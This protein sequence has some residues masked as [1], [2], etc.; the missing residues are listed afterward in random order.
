MPNYLLTITI[1]TATR[2]RDLRSETLLDT[3][4]CVQD[5]VPRSQRIV[6]FNLQS[7]NNFFVTSDA[8]QI[9]KWSVHL[10][11]GHV[12]RWS[13]K[14]SWC[15]GVRGNTGLLF[16]VLVHQYQLQQ[17]RNLSTLFRVL[18]VSVSVSHCHQGSLE[19]HSSIMCEWRW[20]CSSSRKK[21][22]QYWETYL[23]SLAVNRNSLLLLDMSSPNPNAFNFHYH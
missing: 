10:S 22:H 16:L 17:E 4:R 11:S 23:Y 3:D 15:N 19:A 6:R 9:L 14:L 7:S 1:A 12:T 5:Q 13:R 18:S 21:I 20:R 2:T 8:R